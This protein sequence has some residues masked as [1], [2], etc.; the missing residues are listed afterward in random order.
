MVESQ[1]R[2]DS[3][4][5]ASRVCAAN[6]RCSSDRNTSLRGIRLGNKWGNGNSD[7]ISGKTIRLHILLKK[8]TKKWVKHWNVQWSA[9]NPIAMKLRMGKNPLRT[10]CRTSIYSLMFVFIS[11]LNSLLTE[12][13]WG[14][15]HVTSKGSL[16]CNSV[17][18][19]PRKMLVWK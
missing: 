1:Q 9:N 13:P 6:L 14:I 15:A 10:K 2:I 4:S 12:S 19:T 8:H 18:F 3:P 17:F 7:E 16:R 5:F 11:R